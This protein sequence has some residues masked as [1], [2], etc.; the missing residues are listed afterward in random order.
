MS[1]SAYWL[2]ANLREGKTHEEIAALAE[3]SFGSP[4]DLVDVSRACDM[5]VAK[6]EE[7]TRIID[8]RRRRRYLFRVRVL[9]ESMVACLARQLHGLF[10]RWGMLAYATLICA[11][12]IAQLISDGPGQLSRF[13]PGGKMADVYLIYLLALAAHELGHAVACSRYGVKPGGIGFAVYLVFPALYCDVTR[14][15][16][17]PRRQRVVVDVSGIVFE[18]G[19]GAVLATIG[20]ALHQ[21]VFTLASFLILS[22]L[23]WALN[24]FGRFDMYWTLAD[25][26]GIVDL[27]AETWRVLRELL[28]KDR[29]GSHTRWWR[30]FLVAGCGTCAVGII[31]AFSYYVFRVDIPLAAR[32]PAIVRAVRDNLLRGRIVAALSTALEPTTMFALLGVMFYQPVAAGLRAALMRASRIRASKS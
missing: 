18:I 27:R 10:S 14:A 1:P 25:A 22:N 15:W 19:A 11:A 13:N 32:A 26:L 21:P 6:V 12:V 28:R 16:L 17:L 3:K 31:G 9:P 7:E 2:F 29:G 8:A 20:G 30:R 4:L 5:V 24:P 23:V